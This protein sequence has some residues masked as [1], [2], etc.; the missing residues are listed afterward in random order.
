[1]KINTD[2]TKVMIIGQED[3]N[4]SIKLNEESIEHIEMFK[5]L[6]VKIQKY[7]KC[8]AEINKRIENINKLYYALNNTF[9]RRKEISIKTKMT[10]GIQLQYSN[11]DQFLNART[12]LLRNNRKGKY[13][14]W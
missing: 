2:S 13:K 5:Y 12:R 9:I 11:L 1:M 3:I 14:Q 10:V 8:H 4:I 6:G 7:G